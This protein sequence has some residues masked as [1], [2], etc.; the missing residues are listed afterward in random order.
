MENALFKYFFFIL[1]AGI[2]FRFLSSVKMSD[3]YCEGLLPP[4][5]YVFTSESPED[6]ISF[7]RA[8]QT[9]PCLE[10]DLIENR[11]T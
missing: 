10:V 1:F 11:K 9:V 8:G 2:Y 4:I 7:P 6:K 5:T 3:F